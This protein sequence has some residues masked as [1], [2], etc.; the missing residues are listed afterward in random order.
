MPNE[1]E[2]ENA[3]QNLQNETG[4]SETQT[5]NDPV[6]LAE[7]FRLINKSNKEAAESSNEERVSYDSS[8]GQQGGEQ[9]ESGSVDDYSSDE[10]YS[11][12]SSTDSG[13]AGVSGG[14]S[15]PG[16]TVNYSNVRDNF[17]KSAL[18]EAERSVARMFQENNV[19]LMTIQDIYQR[20]EDGTVIF[21]NPDN[22]NRPFESRADAQQWINSINTQINASYQDEVRKAKAE[23]YQNIT[24]SLRVF[25]FIEKYN[26]MDPDVASVF[27]DLID[28]YSVRDGSGKIIGFNC[29]LDAAAAQAESIVTKI[30]GNNPPAQKQQAQKKPQQSTPA[31]DMKTGVG[32]SNDSEPKTLQEAWLKMTKERKNNG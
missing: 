23:M 29:D 4:D 25:S 28:P 13:G 5:S 26:K 32:S 2:N 10:S 17:I 6:D 16:P 9:G 24:P 15:A 3:T 14:Y 31:M 19:R 7:A 30:R 12:V 20:N 18:D 22:P 27:D 1:Y 21:K 8:A 11:S